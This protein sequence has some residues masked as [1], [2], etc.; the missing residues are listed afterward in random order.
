MELS[1][2]EGEEGVERSYEAPSTLLKT[3]IA[4]G[5]RKTT[6]REFYRRLHGIYRRICRRRLRA[7]FEVLKVKK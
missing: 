5:F 7:I 2:A 3:S 4:I 1:F 6:Y